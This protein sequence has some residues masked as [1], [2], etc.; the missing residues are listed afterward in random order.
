MP[1]DSLYWVITHNCNDKCDHCY[2]ASAPKAVELTLDE[3]AQVIEHFPSPQ[4]APLRIIISGGEPLVNRKLLYACLDGLYERYG[5]APQYMLQTNGDLLTAEILNEILSHHITRISIASIDRFH[6][7]KGERAGVLRTLM[8]SRGM[9]YDE[10]GALISKERLTESKLSFSMWGANEDFWIGGNWPR[11]RA[12]E[13][14]LYLKVPAHN[15]CAIPSGAKGFAG[16]AGTVQEI[17]VQLYNLYP[18]CPGT[19]MPLADLRHEN[20]TDAV[21]KV[22]AHPMWQALN[23]GEPSQMGIYKGISE[24]TATGRI[25]ALGN[26]CLWCDEFF[27]KHYE[28]FVPNTSE[29]H[30]NLHHAPSEM[31]VQISLPETLS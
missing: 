5:D 19:R 12:I 13:N 29:P 3:A 22:T 17:A 30:Q 15:F 23:K 8:E 28:A 2:N 26:V 14:G 10:A 25:T 9:I 4:A 6:K 31:F 21:E 7:A 20:L 24:A 1:L 11:G 18:C 16:L 27:E